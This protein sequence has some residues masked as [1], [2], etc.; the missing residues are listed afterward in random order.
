MM[1]RWTKKEEKRLLDLHQSGHT[2]QE[3]A[4]SLRRSAGSVRGKLQ[5]LKEK[6]EKREETRES[7]Y[8]ERF[9][10]SHDEVP[11]AQE[12]YYELTLALLDE[13][14]KIREALPNLG[15][16]Y[17]KQKPRLYNNLCRMAE[18]LI[19]LLKIKPD[20]T[21]IQEW[22]D[23]IAIKRLPKEARR[24]PRRVMQRWMKGLRK[25]SKTRRNSVT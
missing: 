5:R 12:I 7:I 21:S 1:T 2:Y 8:T 9:S 16:K 22:F 4:D 11:E 10:A 14:R 6:R 24:E 23:K 25:L 18:T 17:M 20:K 13:F 19:S 15:Q 3:I